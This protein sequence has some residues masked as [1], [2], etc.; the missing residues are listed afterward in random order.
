MAS[1]SN[2]TLGERQAP[3]TIQHVRERRT[4]TP[5]VAP[6]RRRK[7]AGRSAI[8]ALVMLAA[9]TGS[10]AGLTLVYSVNLPQ[11]EDL[12]Q[13]RPSTMTDL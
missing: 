10:L 2:R 3:R 7:L 9:I 6:R 4:R 12:E 5:V 13:Y 8:A 11:I 1:T